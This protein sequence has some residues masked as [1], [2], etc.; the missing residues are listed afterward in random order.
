MPASAEDAEAVAPQAADTISHP[1]RSAPRE[2]GAGARRRLPGL[3]GG[4]S[5]SGERSG[6]ERDRASV[7][8]DAPGLGRVITLFQP[9]ERRQQQQRRRRRPGLGPRRRRERDRDRGHRA[10]EAGEH[11]GQAV[12]E[13]GSGGQ[14]RARDRCRRLAVAVAGEARGDQR[15]VVGPD[16]SGVV[17]E[18]VVAGLAW[19]R[20]C[21]PPSPN[22]ARPR[23]AA[24]R[25][26]RPR[27]RRGVPDQSRWPMF[28]LRLST[29]RLS[30]SRAS[31]WQP[32]SGIQKSRRKGSRS[33]L[34]RPSRRAASAS[35]PQTSRASRAA[36]RWAS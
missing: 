13:V 24:R 22:R 8:R 25:S 36:R 10:R 27:P 19:R 34:A 2:G 20:A 21:G 9:Q 4:R 23:A 3:C 30:P 33:A 17:A 12:L 6:L 5:R 18:R 35:S 31:A 16:G 14:D 7:G 1:R 26:P 28:E 29:W 11:L 32:R 15:V